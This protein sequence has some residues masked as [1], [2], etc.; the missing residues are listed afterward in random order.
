M[1]RVFGDVACTKVFFRHCALRRGLRLTVPR[2][3]FAFRPALSH[4]KPSLLPIPGNPF[5][6]TLQIPHHRPEPLP[7]S[8]RRPAL[9]F[10]QFS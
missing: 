9:D 4:V 3:Q 7:M 6:Y 8:S 5:G 1:A 10:Q 2:T